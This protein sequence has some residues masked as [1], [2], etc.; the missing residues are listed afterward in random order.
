MSGR[1]TKNSEIIES[2]SLIHELLG[3]KL[4]ELHTSE[5]RLAS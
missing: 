2:E 5:T 4:K 3:G 1:T